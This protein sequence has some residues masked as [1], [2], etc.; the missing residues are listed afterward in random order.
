MA[1]VHPGGS[2]TGRRRWSAAKTKLTAMHGFNDGQKG[3]TMD[4]G[5]QYVPIISGVCSSEGG[6][7]YQEDMAVK[8]GCSSG[9]VQPMGVF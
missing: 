1:A 8:V 7:S 6:K 5:L 3:T 4:S 2:G 9:W